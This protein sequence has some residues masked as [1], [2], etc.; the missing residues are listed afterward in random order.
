MRPRRGLPWRLP[1]RF[2]VVQ[3]LDGRPKVS[4]VRSTRPRSHRGPTFDAD[5]AGPLGFLAGR[6]PLASFSLRDFRM[7]FGGR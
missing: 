4:P 2:A 1:V 5:P 3:W 7:T 6:R